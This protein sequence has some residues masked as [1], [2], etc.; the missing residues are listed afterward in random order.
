MLLLP[1]FAASEDHEPPSAPLAGRWLLAR[2][3]IGI[4]GFAARGSLLRR[5]SRFG[6]EGWKPCGEPTA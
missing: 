6:C 1:S 5:S 3:S 2:R 4:G